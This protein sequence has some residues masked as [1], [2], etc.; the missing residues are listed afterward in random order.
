MAMNK[1]GR[2]SPKTTDPK[3][4]AR[5]ADPEVYGQSLPGDSGKVSS[6]P[7]LRTMFQSGKLNEQFFGVGGTKQK[8]TGGE[9]SSYPS[10]VKRYLEGKTD[11]LDDINYEEP[12]ISED[13]ASPGSTKKIT[14][15]NIN[16][17][18]NSPKWKSI[19][20][21]T[22]IPGKKYTPSQEGVNQQVAIGSTG[23][24]G[25]FFGV[26]TIR[27]RKVD[28]ET[29]MPEPTPTQEPTPTLNKKKSKPLSV[30]VPS[31]DNSIQWSAPEPKG[32]K[33]KRS[34]IKSKE[35]GQDS[36]VKPLSMT[37]VPKEGGG[38]RRVPALL[39]GKEKTEQSKPK[40]FRYKREEKIAKSFYAPK[41]ELGFGGYYNMTGE[42]FDEQGK[43]VD[44]AKLIKSKR[45]DIR[46]S[47]KDFRQNSI[48]QGD[49]KKDRIN[50]YR[51]AMKKN[52]LST[53]LARRGDISAVGDGTWKE[54]LNS[55]LE[56]WTPDYN[57]EGDRGA[58]YNYVSS[59][60]R[61]ISRI[62][63]LKK[64][65]ISNYI[66]AQVARGAKKENYI[67]SAEDNA[68]NRNSTQAR[69]SQFWGWNKK[70]K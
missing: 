68:T 4:G 15:A 11:I 35:G 57:K 30:D 70:V 17:K 55:K 32:Y 44:I 36:K 67:K 43:S 34:I 16:Y 53:R 42:A 38:V 41:D 19:I 52:R 12:I 29:I 65:E 56:Y 7:E 63:Q 23:G 14:R 37:L 40:G 60:E 9:Y 2:F 21:K 31:V 25:E 27:E 1:Y 3:T 45:K 61:D 66:N 58:M 62:N 5:I 22:S 48:L 50:D 39:V 26:S 6:W 33:T 13:Y 59:A 64:A 54:G 46:E 20:K 8:P 49:Q 47:R 51:E 10:D 69:M 28:P 18:V 24:Y